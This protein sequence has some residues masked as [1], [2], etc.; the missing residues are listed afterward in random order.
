MFSK[1]QKAT[2]GILF[3]L[4]LLQSFPGVTL[5]YDV[6]GGIRRFVSSQVETSD[7]IIN[8]NKSRITNGIKTRS[9]LL[10]QKKLEHVSVLESQLGK[11][12]QSKPYKIHKSVSLFTVGLEAGVLN[13]I[14]NLGAE[15]YSL[16]AKIPTAPE[17]L[18]NFGFNYTKNP[19]KYHNKVTNGTKAIAG[20][21]L[22]PKP[23][24]T[25]AKNVY[26]ESAKDP[27]KFGKL[28]GGTTA[29]IGSFFVMGGGATK[30]ASS[31]N[32]AKNT[33]KIDELAKTTASINKM[34]SGGLF[35]KLPHFN[36]GFSW[37]PTPTLAGVGKG[38]GG[39]KTFVYNENLATKIEMKVSSLPGKGNVGLKKTPAQVDINKIPTLRN[40]AYKQ[41]E[42]MANTGR[43][44]NVEAAQILKNMVD[45]SAFRVA[46]PYNKSLLKAFKKGRLPS[47]VEGDRFFDPD[48]FGIQKALEK[49]RQ[50]FG[51]A[52]GT[53]PSKYEVDGFLGDIK[54][55]SSDDFIGF[56][57]GQVIFNL[58]KKALF[59]RTTMRIVDYYDRYK[60]LRMWP[61]RV[62]NIN[63]ICA[64]SENIPKITSKLKDVKKVTPADV[65][66]AVNG[67]YYKGFRIETQYHGGVS[68]ENINSVIFREKA[69]P[70][71][72]E[73][74]EELTARK[75]PT[76]VQSG[77][78]SKKIKL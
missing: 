57:A 7:K 77:T 48:G 29:Y 22:N 33:A 42:F 56:S 5:G 10:E 38:S 27:L 64:P 26:L 25:Y 51:T 53:P 54:I 36:K 50:L 67:E 31:A 49:S 40:L 60:P 43:E 16:G 58:D 72:K 62:D 21:A 68:V 44:S 11:N 3:L 13:G 45:N 18:I 2:S 17:R 24:Y 15:F 46:L 66:K 4:M 19:A 63:T 74:I 20:V 41:K 34:G 35:S 8:K 55:G 32:K 70:L 69:P 59:P 71:G 30:I 61:S 28:H 39:K 52:K 12:S 37:F 76:F 9:K 78:T 14:S 75:I 6:L 23:L 47:T 65:A 73:L 1:K